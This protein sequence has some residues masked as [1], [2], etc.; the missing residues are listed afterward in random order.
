MTEIPH[1]PGIPTATAHERV[2]Q[3]LLP[4][5]TAKLL[6]EN[7]NGAKF[8]IECQPAMLAVM[9]QM[10]NRLLSEIHA[11]TKETQGEWFKTINEAKTTCS[12]DAR[13]TLG[14][15]F[16]NGI[17]HIM[18]FEVAAQLADLIGKM[19]DQF[20]TPEMRAERLRVRHGKAAIIT[21]SGSRIIRP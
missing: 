9:D 21:P 12:N 2:D 11:R 5:N 7:P 16:D 14:I 4:D 20:E 13:G 18:N 1:E 15:S 10:I 17:V 6:F 19:L 8:A 3:F